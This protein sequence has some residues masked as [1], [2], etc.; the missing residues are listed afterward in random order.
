MTILV[1]F[2]GFDFDSIFNKEFDVN[3]ISIFPSGN[4][5]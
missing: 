1:F 4:S 5:M 2:S 3:L